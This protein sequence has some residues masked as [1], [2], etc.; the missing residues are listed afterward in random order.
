[1]FSRGSESFERVSL[2]DIDGREVL[3][4]YLPE[5][6]EIPC[7]ISSPFRK[8]ER[9][10][11][12]IF[13]GSNRGK[14]LWKDYATGEHGDMADLVARLC[15]VELKD[16]PEY[17]KSVSGAAVCTERK[18]HI[19]ESRTSVRTRMREWRPYDFRYWQSY[20]VPEKWVR[21]AGIYPVSHIFIVSGNGFVNTIKADM[22]AYTFVERKDG[23]LTEKVYQPYNRQ[24]FKWR[25]GNNLSVIDLWTKLPRKGDRLII[26]SSR[27]DALC[28]WANT[29]IPSISPQSESTGIKPQVIKELRERFMDIYI[30]YDND[31]EGS[32]NWGRKDAEKLHM[33]YGL[34]SIYVPDMYRCKDPSDLYHKYGKETFIKVMHDL[35]DGE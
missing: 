21:H 26:T 16:V 19:Q 20:G 12:G 10:S 5:V 6:H 24:G 32:E 28:I 31:L 23:I 9:P 17:L 3:S 4:L 2:S 1:M 29:G 18:V 34:P 13:Y 15:S 11:F 27:K 7:V 8:D 33:E 30:M 22:Y 25:S 35:L 14:I